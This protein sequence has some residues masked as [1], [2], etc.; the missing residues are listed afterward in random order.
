MDLI[1]DQNDISGFFDLVNESF[2]AAFKLAAELG[3]C[4]HGGHIQHINFLVQKLIGYLTVHDPLGKSFGNGGFTNTGL[5]DETGI[6][7]LTAVEDLNHTLSLRITAYN[8]VDLAFFGLSGQVQAVGFQELSLVLFSLRLA[9]FTLSLL[10][11]FRLL[12][13]VRIG[14]ELA[15][16]R[17]SGS[18]A[19]FL[20]ILI[21]LIHL[22]HQLIAAPQN[23][24]HFSGEVFQILLGN[25]HF[26][27]HVIN[28]LYAQFPGTF[29]AK[30]FIFGLTVFNFRNKNHS[31]VLFTSAAQ[32]GT[33]IGSPLS[34]I[35]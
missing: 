28:G 1:N 9:G 12:R 10:G 34:K 3:S 21:F 4:H 30:T 20:F 13:P 17:E 19:I 29:Q 25:A 27:H 11:R 22:G 16:I 32:T 6:I 31:I 2:H 14:E 26:L 33:H 35:L 23:A 18:T 24:H 8:A 15:E 7:L 5:T